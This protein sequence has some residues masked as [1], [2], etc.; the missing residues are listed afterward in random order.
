[1]ISGIGSNNDISKMVADMFEKINNATI[2]IHKK[3]SNYDENND[4]DAVEFAKTLEKAFENEEI[5]KTDNLN[6]ISK[7]QL[8]IPLGLDIDMGENLIDDKQIEVSGSMAFL[9]NNSFFD[10]NDSK[11]IQTLINNYKINKLV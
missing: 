3:D 10:K 1:M 11:F 2:N 4:F 7:E 8:G 9:N 6:L 5:K